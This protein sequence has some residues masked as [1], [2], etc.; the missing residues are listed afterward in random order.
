MLDSSDLATH[1][2]IRDIA[3]VVMELREQSG[4]RLDVVKQVERS[5]MPNQARS[6]G[7][8]WDRPTPEAKDRVRY[9]GDGGAFVDIVQ[10][11]VEYWTRRRPHLVCHISQEALL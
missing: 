3:L 8:Y 11:E 4:S 5:G 10:V 9:G 7:L 2:T 1:Q 6:I